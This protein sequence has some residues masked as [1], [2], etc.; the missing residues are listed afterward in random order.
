MA[1]IASLGLAEA[2]AAQTRENSPPLN[3]PTVPLVKAE[4]GP[5]KVRPTDPGGFKVPHRDKTIYTRIETERPKIRPGQSAELINKPGKNNGEPTA[6]YKIQI[7]I[8]H[9]P[10][11]AE[12]FWAKV[13]D[14]NSAMIGGFQ[15]IIEKTSI[16]SGKNSIYRLQF[17]PVPSL[18]EGQRICGALTARKIGCFLVKAS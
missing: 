5:A 9:D 13:R 7:G 1:A 8:F 10:A 2:P 11:A 17:G 18:T 14:G 16:N 4:S 15:K 6:K 3:V 12:R